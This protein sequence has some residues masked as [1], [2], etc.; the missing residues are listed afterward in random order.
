MSRSFLMLVWWLLL[1]ALADAAGAHDNPRNS[2]AAGGTGGAA[3]ADHCSSH[4]AGKVLIG[5]KGRSGGYVD[6]IRG[7]CASVNQVLMPESVSSTTHRGGSG[8]STAYE[9]RCPTGHALVGLHGRAGFYIDQVGIKCAPLDTT[10]RDGRTIG[11]PAAPE[12]LAGSFARATSG[13][14]GGTAFDLTC[15]G[16]LPARTLMGRAGTFVDRLQLGCHPARVPAIAPAQAGLDVQPAVRGMPLVIPRDTPVRVQIE[17][18]NVGTVPMPI[19]EDRFESEAYVDVRYTWGMPILAVEFLGHGSC[20]N[21]VFPARCTPNTRWQPGQFL[22]IHG[23]W[24]GGSDTGGSITATAGI[25]NRLVRLGGSTGE[26]NTS[27]NQIV[28]AG[29]QSR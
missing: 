21:S 15:P 10:A 7:I 20:D 24:G 28:V 12:G 27:N 26:V 13:G 2:G 18:W 25:Y 6:S 14:S 4:A 5:I 8:G 22:Q 29:A 3:F 9:F 11:T 16:N 23:N 1:L 19:G 17:L